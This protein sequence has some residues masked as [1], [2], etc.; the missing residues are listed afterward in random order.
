MTFGRMMSYFGLAIVCLILGDLA[1][2]KEAKEDFQKKENIPNPVVM[3]QTTEKKTDTQP[4][5]EV[6]TL[7]VF[8]PLSQKEFERLYEE[9]AVQHDGMG[10]G[11]RQ[12]IM[13]S[14]YKKHRRF[15]IAQIFKLRSLM[16]NSFGYTVQ[17]D[18]DLCNELRYDEVVEIEVDAL[19]PDSKP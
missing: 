13:T 7:K 4:I 16:K 2:H 11:Y 8:K 12:A 17:N 6:V 5:K 14:V 18:L 10:D 1:G 19:I 3:L 15:T 9:I